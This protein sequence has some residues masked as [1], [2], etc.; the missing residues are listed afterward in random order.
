[1]SDPLIGAL[2]ETVKTDD[3]VLYSI[4]TG[5]R[6]QIDGLDGQINTPEVVSKVITNAVETPGNVANFNYIL[7]QFNVF[8]TWDFVPSAVLYEIRRGNVWATASYVTTV[9]SLQ[10]VLNPLLTGT[11]R[12]LIK[13][14]N[15]EG[16]QSSVETLLDVIIPII[17]SPIV[18][19]TNVVNTALLFWTPPDSTFKID[20][21]KITRNSAPL[22]T[23][24]GTFLA[25]PEAGAGTF[26][27]GIAAVDIAG[28]VGIEGVVTV[29]V[30]APTDYILTAILTSAF[31]GAKTNALK[32]SIADRDVLE[33]CLDLAETYHDHYSTRGWAT[34]QDQINAG[35]PYYGEPA[36]NTASYVEVFD[37]GAAFNNIVVGV[38]WLYNLITGAVG[39][40]STLEFSTDNI[41][42]TA[43][44]SGPTAFASSVRYVRL[45]INFA[46]NAHSLL[47]FYYLQCSLSVHKE[48]DGG[49]GTA[50]SGDVGGTSF[51]FNKTFL[52]VESVTCTARSTSNLVCVTNSITT[53]GFKVEVF[54]SAGVRQTST[55]DWKA[56]GII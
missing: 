19:G 8:L 39:L 23:I 52:S 12:F 33:V 4:L 27:Y 56:R 9:G 7:T 54:D 32:T 1:M 40:T 24:T 18:N 45:T 50:N 41:T 25:Y 5:L 49:S 10:V 47:E 38:S 44:V 15:S 6:R 17:Q 48:N 2:I 34:P 36:N 53:T 21:Y 42:F 37:F 35:Y 28:N 26:S 11:T 43:P 22:T 14:I 29:T 46:G 55:I 13:A 51:T 20:Y 31:A 16:I 30:T 3:P